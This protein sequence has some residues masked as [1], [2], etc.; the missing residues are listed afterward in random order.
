MSAVAWDGTITAGGARPVPYAIFAKPSS[1]VLGS[2]A[3]RCVPQ[4]DAPVPTEAPN[5]DVA[6]YLPVTAM[7]S[8]PQ[9]IFSLLPLTRASLPGMSTGLAAVRDSPERENRTGI[10][11][12]NSA[13]A[14]PRGAP[15]TSAPVA[16]ARSR[17][18]APLRLSAVDAAR[19]R[20]TEV[21]EHI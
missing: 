8:L 19:A 5:L 14:V 20:R 1:R 15:D 4:C 12:D 16:G 3:P 9:F 7:L 10:P 11:V 2:W 17:G 13:T 18:A 21:I 6:V